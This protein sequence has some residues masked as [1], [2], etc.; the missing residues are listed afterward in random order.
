MNI[1]KLL[2]KRNVVILIGVCIVIT[3]MVVSVLLFKKPNSKIDNKMMIAVKNTWATT[4]TEEQPLYLTKLEESSSYE[5]ISVTNEDGL[6]IITAEITAP[7]VS[8]QLQTVDA[9]DFPKTEDE[10]EINQF[11]CEQIEKSKTV[12]TK[13]DIYAY[14]INGEY[15]ISYSD[16]F[17]NAMSGNLCTYS[18]T[19]LTDMLE[20]FAKGELK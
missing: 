14:E 5:L 4:Q 17:I 12:K 11:L 9:E 18:Q 19:A 6:Y 10:N 13:A 3:I 1:K 2:S 8:K 15:Q 20:K 7:D 16:S